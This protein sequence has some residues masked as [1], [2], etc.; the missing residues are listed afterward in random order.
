MNK[1]IVIGLI[2]TAGS[3]LIFMLAMILIVMIA[4]CFLGRYV[5]I[6]RKMVLSTLGVILTGVLVFVGI[7]LYVHLVYPD[8]VE[9][10]NTGSTIPEVQDIIQNVSFMSSVISNALVF[11]YAFIFFLLAFKEKRLL[12][13][14]ESTICLYL[15]YS[16]FNTA[17]MYAYVFF[18]DGKVETLSLFTD[19]TRTDYVYLQFLLVIESLI[20]TVLLFLLIYFRYYRK[21]KFYV[22]SIPNR[23]IFVIWLIAFS[24]FPSFPFNGKDVGE[25]YEILGVIFAIL[26]MVLG[27]IAPVL[28]IMTAAEK[29]LKEKNKYQESYLNAEL[30][31]IDQYKRTQTETRAFRHD[32][33]N[34]LS[35][36][37]MLLKEGKTKE[38]EEHISSLLGNVQALSPQYITGDEMLDCIVAMKAGRMQE[39]GIEFTSDGVI[40]GGLNMKPVD[41]CSIFANALDNAIEAVNKL[42]ENRKVSL[43]I[44]RTGKFFVIKIENTA[45][46]KV[47]VEKLFNTAG[48]TSK[49]DTEHHGFGLRN[50]RQTVEEYDGLIKAES[51]EGR[52]ALSVMVPRA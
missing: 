3:Y 28:L 8:Y 50:I 24:I 12:R 22:I 23:I 21:K 29:S 20:I 47:D 17:F 31:Y 11:V 33:I 35:L 46:G 14:I 6:T 42:E 52:F 34:N 15:Y 16:Y 19:Y 4:A 1:N 5:V 45:E 2:S 13:A 25:M 26:I 10:F 38:A 39:L 44:K 9:S 7:N 51:E 49:S 18:K 37:N 43:G 30:E 48:Y 36:A 40:D 27:A 32:I 41:V